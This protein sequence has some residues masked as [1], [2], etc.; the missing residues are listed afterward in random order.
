MKTTGVKLGP[1]GS[2]PPRTTADPAAASP[3][4]VVEKVTDK[5]AAS[6]AAAE[7]VRSGGAKYGA[8]EAKADQHVA[9][10]QL[11][12]ISLRAPRPDQV[13][14]L[15]AMADGK[16]VV[17]RAAA[18]AFIDGIVKGRKDGTIDSAEAQV[19]QLLLGNDLPFAA[20]LVALAKGEAAP[21]TVPDAASA[22]A[23]GFAARHPWFDGQTAQLVD[24]K[25]LLGATVF[26][27]RDARGGTLRLRT[28]L[29]EPV[30][31]TLVRPGS[32]P[33]TEALDGATAL[34]LSRLLLGSMR[35]SGALGA[36]GDAF[37]KDRQA[38]V[39]LLD[40]AGPTPPGFVLPAGVELDGALR[41]WDSKLAPPA[42]LADGTKL[43]KL[44]AMTGGVR[45]YAMD[46]ELFAPAGQAETGTLYRRYHAVDPA[47]G[48]WK[49]RGPEPLNASEAD[50]IRAALARST[51]EGHWENAFYKGMQ[52]RTL[53][54][55][56]Y[57][58]AAKHES[59][60]VQKERS[61]RR[62]VVRSLADLA[63]KV[64]VPHEARLSILQSLDKMTQAD[65]DMPIEA[66]QLVSDALR[67]LEKSG[68]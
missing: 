49:L 68:A 2:S 13:A 19:F 25:D 9:R 46:V 40:R 23:G 62:D 51:D 66:R 61:A 16:P 65:L 17:D 54:D 50:A 5:V 34:E 12:A 15:G 59:L 43:E 39:A 22:S 1:L 7:K 28:A 31:L 45:G 4:P 56:L 33:V 60:D 64:D 11:D 55:T 18:A 41:P 47:G 57:G 38:Y 26:D 58:V 44:A 52:P 30:Q 42:P 3:S 20:H 6:A 48:G 53:L 14:L 37:A 24:R 27:L 36:D 63:F 35:K 8:T 10:P 32:A 21:I 29:D 67:R